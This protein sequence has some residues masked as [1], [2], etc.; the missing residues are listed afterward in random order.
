[1]LGS[2]H[3][4]PPLVAAGF[5]WI[6]LDQQHGRFDD[7]S[8]IQGIAELRGSPAT[9]V[10]R[11]R[12][13]DAGLIGRALDS[14]SDGVI[15]PMVSTAEQAA[16]AVRATY[17]PPLGER[18]WGPIAADYGTSTAEVNR[19][20]LCAVM[21][22]TPDALAH[23]DEIAATPGLS[24]IFVGPFDLSIALG[25]DVD[26]LLADFTDDSP[27]QVVVASCRAA[28]ITAGAFAG[29]PERAQLLL[30]HGFTFVAAATDGL[31]VTRGGQSQLK[32]AGF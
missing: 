23:I 4:L 13:L 27:L 3:L 17:Y 31:I 6:C 18:S 21:V 32:L 2:P 16:A 12:S 10:V 5:E 29:T 1:M 8:T 24:M 22:E 7:S 28:G 20:I 15:V 26:G 9:V 30:K 14:G 19:D 11:V 25:R